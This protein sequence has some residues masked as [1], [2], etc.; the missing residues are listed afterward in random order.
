MDLCQHPEA[1]KLHGHTMQQGVPL[2]PLVPLFAFAKTRLHADILA[3]PIE[4]WEA[5]YV[6]YEP[7]WEGKTMN[8]VLWRGVYSSNCSSLHD[9][10]ADWRKPPVP[11]LSGSTTGV[12]FNRHTPWRRSQRARLH[13]MSHETEGT[14]K[15]IWSRRGQLR[16]ANM[17]V[18]AINDHYMD[19]SFS[20]ALQQCDPETCELLEKK[21]DI[22]PTIGLDESNT[23][24]SRL[25]SCRPPLLPSRC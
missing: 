1:R 14:K 22:K 19:T 18:A 12:E 3:V 10:T 15:I 20:G 4:Q 13:I 5:H 25:L 11:L 17:S 8:K 7:P 6:G 9:L 23:V 24:R 21:F 16:E 2:G